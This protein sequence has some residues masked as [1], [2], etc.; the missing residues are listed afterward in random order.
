MTIVLLGSVGWGQNLPAQRFTHPLE[1]GINTVGR[2][3]P[4]LL[5][6]DRDIVVEGAGSNDDIVLDSAPH[7]ADDKVSPLEDSHVRGGIL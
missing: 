6:D 7:S 1:N 5:G 2:G 3:E 4:L